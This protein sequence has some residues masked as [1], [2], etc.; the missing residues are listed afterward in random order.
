MEMTVAKSSVKFKFKKDFSSSSRATFYKFIF[1]FYSRRKLAET[2]TISD[3][4]ERS[5]D[6]LS[7]KS[8][9]VGLLDIVY[10]QTSK[11]QKKIINIT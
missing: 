8:S 7:N 5:L 10:L 3:Y 9:D 4:F 1:R 6:Y 11:I 2:Y